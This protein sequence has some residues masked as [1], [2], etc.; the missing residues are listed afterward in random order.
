[1]PNANIHKYQKFNAHQDSLQLFWV[2]SEI[3]GQIYN[4]W[5]GN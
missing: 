2:V 4:Y 3:L 1:M 5:H